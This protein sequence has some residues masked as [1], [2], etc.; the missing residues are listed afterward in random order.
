MASSNLKWRLSP[1]APGSD[2]ARPD[3]AAGQANPARDEDFALVQRLVSG[4][5]EA[6]QVFVVR[7]QR[8]VLT[9]VLVATRET[10]QA[11]VPSD[12]EDLCAEVFSQL[13]SADY[14]MLRRFEGRST[15]S[16]WLSVVTRRIVLRRLAVANREPSRPIQRL[17]PS[18]D[19]LPSPAEQG[20]LADMICG[21]ENASLA[22]A[23]AR[24]GERQR[25][26]AQLFYIEGRSYRQISEQLQM[27]MNSIGPTLAR[28][29]D[30]L[31]V[32]LK[33]GE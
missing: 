16:T 3:S 7:F 29:H 10:G 14:G 20:P 6:W 31:R 24:L 4:N 27:P 19:S 25:Q 26:I 30:K 17:A 22:A 8:L 33:Q 21:E 23:V 15:I 32:V 11:L 12:A 13:I 2:P 5:A 28:I 18:L 1:V 9:R